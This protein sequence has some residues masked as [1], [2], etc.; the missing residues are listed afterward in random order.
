[1]NSSKLLHKIEELTKTLNEKEDEIER[2]YVRLSDE[3]DA[4]EKRIM[5]KQS[6]V[7]D[8]RKYSEVLEKELHQSRVQNGEHLMKQEKIQNLLPNGGSFM[9]SIPSHAVQVELADALNK[10][11]QSMR[12]ISLLEEKISSMEAESQYL[13]SLR[14]ELQASRL[15]YENLLE[16]HG[17][18]IER[19]E[20]LELDLADLKKLL[21]D[22]TEYFL[23]KS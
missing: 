21:K 23:G 13:G 12:Q 7:D 9:L 4:F 20:E 17:E 14:Q 8:A 5:Q 15:R 19:I 10:Y 1:M 16:A 11:E 18:K 6:E 2:V 22:Q 3:A